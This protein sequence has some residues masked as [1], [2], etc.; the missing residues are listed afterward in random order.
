MEG[1]KKI[2][3]V[4][5]INAQVGIKIQDLHFNHTWLKKGDKFAIPFELLEQILFDTGSR[6]MFENG[7]LYINDMQAKI[8]LGLEPEGAIE[9]ENIIVLDDAQRKR[10]MTVL[11]VHEF[12]QKLADLSMDQA[13]ALAQYA[14]ENKLIDFDKCDMLKTMTGIDIIKSIEYNREV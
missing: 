2:E 5:T 10:Y 11:P 6:N 14:I 4:N 13:T 1:N 8:E 9:P 3:V 7:T 12:K